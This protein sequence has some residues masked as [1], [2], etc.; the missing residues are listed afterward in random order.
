MTPQ[1][2]P[3]RH[4]NPVA[5]LSLAA[6]LLPATAC[7]E[8][9]PADR[10]RVSG[11]VEATEIQVAAEVGGRLLERRV[12]EG[13]RAAPGDLLARLDTADVTL[14]LT[15]ATAERQAADAQLR[16]LLAGARAE[17]IR[18]ADAQR[19]AAEADLAAASRELA[20]AE[21]DL[22]RF[23]ALIAS[24]SGVQKQRDDAAA[25]RDVAGDRVR[26]AAERA[27]AASEAL[28]RLKA[29]ARPEEIDAARARLAVADAQ[30]AT[31]DK[32]L[33]DASVTA[34]SGGLV[35]QTL[36]DPG[37]LLAPRVPVLVLA[38]LDHVWAN[39]FVDEPYVPRVA[40]GQSATLFT[41][42]GGPGIAGTVT[43][44][45]PKAEFT[46]R[47]VQTAEERSKLVFRIKVSVDNRG[48][49]LKQ[50]MPVEAE[51]PLTK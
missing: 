17:D 27:R 19:A 33:R 26:G 37:E 25:R 39:V 15:R 49:V 34:P 2:R 10:I 5:A 44:I 47:N 16:L 11:Y 43:F 46:P 41:D 14:A 31:L 3:A 40:L 45:S 22:Q 35:T 13:D 38:D 4:P 28:A 12:S 32:A 20:A 36:A 7:H 24:N 21:Q 30:I 9:P 50:G 1:P 23:D 29:G 6:A 18:Q 8:A 42:A 51:I 48:G